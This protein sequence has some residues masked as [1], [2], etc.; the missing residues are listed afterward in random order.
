MV[1]SRLARRLRALQIDSFA[2]YLRLLSTQHAELEEFI[3]ALTTNLTSFFREPHHFRIL[4]TH[5]EKCAGRPI[6]IWTCASSSGE[7][8]YS[9]AMTALETL[10]EGA[11]VRILAT[12]ID[13]RVL[14]AAQEG[15]YPLHQLEKV[16]PQLLHRFFL[17]GD[18]KNSGFARVRE[19]VRRMV[20]FKRLNLLDH[21]W[22]MRWKFD[23]IFC[24]NVMIYFDK[25]TQSELLKRMVPCLQPDGLL[26]VGHSESFHD[27]SEI[28]KLCGNT[29]YTPTN[30]PSRWSGHP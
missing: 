7:E 29:V 17:R 8:P 21:P 5:L 23:A 27:A 6:S 13:T 30:V 24:R 16:P 22:P 26:F 1:Y 14:A 12:D 20:T 28:L 9:I 25:Q 19:E 18:G 11:P 3:N 4:A 10:G 15:V 2:E